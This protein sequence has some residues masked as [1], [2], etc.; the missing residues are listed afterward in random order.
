MNR[1]LH[2]FASNSKAVLEAMS[3][4]DRS[5]DLKDLDLCHDVLPAQCSARHS[6]TSHL[7]GKTATSRTMP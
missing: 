7:V 5:K 4:E 3:A 6:S 1:P 2:K